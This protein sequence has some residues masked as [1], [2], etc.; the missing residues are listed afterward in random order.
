MF[1]NNNSSNNNFILG[2][3][4]IGG[5][6]LATAGGNNS[7]NVSGTLQTGGNTTLQA[8]NDIIFTANGNITT[9]SGNII[10][11]ADNNSDN[12]G[13]GGAV[14][15]DEGTI[16]DAGSNTI[17][18]SADENITL[19]LLTTSNSSTSSITLTSSNGGVRDADT[20]S[21]DIITN[22][23]LV[24]DL[25]TGFG[26]TDNAIETNL[27]SVDIDNSTSGDINIFEL[28]QI[29]IFKINHAGTGDIKVF[30]TKTATNQQN[31][32]ASQGSIAFT[33]RDT[34][35]LVV[36]GTN[37]S[38][39]TLSNERTLQFF[40]IYENIDPTFL[41]IDRSRHY[42]PEL[43]SLDLFSETNALVEIGEGTAA[44]FDGLGKL[45]NV[46]EGT[47]VKNKQIAK[48]K[49]SSKTI[50]S[51][52]PKKTFAKEQIAKIPFKKSPGKT[53]AY[54]KDISGKAKAP[55]QSMR[56]TRKNSKPPEP[57]FSLSQAESL[58]FLP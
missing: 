37:K 13:S 12:N 14:T 4:T 36:P 32:T 25:V 8:D 27:V 19:G 5:N 34:G 53:S 55:Y 38:L 33:R 28:N 58:S 41:P 42:N 26:T 15:M 23:R 45:E 21:L 51:K 47:G 57:L 29:D 11:A 17:A 24:A 52:R 49:R 10:L 56:T 50:L 9:T 6:L 48:R 54:S 46:W 39:K 2:A 31:I 30:F 7:L 16:F 44:Y 1:K 3:S 18:L 43:P 40:T 22:G 35:I 20:N